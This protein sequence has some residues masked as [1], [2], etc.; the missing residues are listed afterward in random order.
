[1]K[2]MNE[3]E[4]TAQVAGIPGRTGSNYV[5]PTDLPQDSRKVSEDYDKDRE[6]QPYP[7]RFRRARIPTVEELRMQ[8]KDALL[9]EEILRAI[10]F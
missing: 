2:T 7:E 5:A 1:M 3:F 10:E 6:Q 8:L 9:R 4:P